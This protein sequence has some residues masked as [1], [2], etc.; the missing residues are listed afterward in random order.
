MKQ[1]W[2]VDVEARTA[3]HRSGFEMNFIEDG[4]GGWRAQ[5][6]ID[7]PSVDRLDIPRLLTEGMEAWNAEIA[8]RSIGQVH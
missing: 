6:V 1:E 4:R 5:R 2:T 7:E 8:R 3:R